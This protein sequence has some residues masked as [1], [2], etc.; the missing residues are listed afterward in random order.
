[1]ECLITRYTGSNFECAAD[2]EEEPEQCEQ[3]HAFF[4]Q[5]EILR[6]G[7]FDIQNAFLELL[8]GRLAVNEIL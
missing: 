1:M 4:Q 5:S 7:V 3:A 8:P 2:A 6:E